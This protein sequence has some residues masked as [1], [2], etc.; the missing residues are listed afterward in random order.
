MQDTCVIIP[1]TLMF[2]PITSIQIKLKHIYTFAES[3][4]FSLSADST[5]ESI[6]PL[7]MGCR[8]SFG[9]GPALLPLVDFLLLLGNGT[10]GLDVFNMG[11]CICGTCVACAMCLFCISW[12]P[13]GD[14]TGGIFTGWISC[15]DTA[16][17]FF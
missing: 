2:K 7:S 13:R 5:N 6:F 9:E 10:S 17:F 1:L 11:F 14:P 16:D 12:V 4:L 3:G 8:N 15:L